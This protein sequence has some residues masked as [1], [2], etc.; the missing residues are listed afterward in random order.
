MVY[1][2]CNGMNRREYNTRPVT[3]AH[4]RRQT[5]S[6]AASPAGR[7]AQINKEKSTAPHATLGR[8]VVMIEPTS[9]RHEDAWPTARRATPYAVRS[10]MPAW[11]KSL[12]DAAAAAGAGRRQSNKPADRSD[13][14]T[15]HMCGDTEVHTRSCSVHVGRNVVGRRRMTAA[16]HRVAH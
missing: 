10:T 5:P 3:H 7:D 14:A 6:R 9:R 8:R 16:S 13:E 2:S 15:G 12:I 4:P 1:Q 11:K